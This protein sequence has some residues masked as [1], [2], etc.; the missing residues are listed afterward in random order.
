MIKVEPANEPAQFDA[1]VRTPGRKYLGS[2]SLSDKPDFRRRNYWKA[3]LRE[4]HS[5]YRGVCAYT[6]HWMTPDVGS[7]TVEHFLPKSAYPGLAYE[8]T[9][10]RLVCSRLNSR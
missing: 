7:D 1:S 9:N 10:Y 2:L 5:S 6:C 4:L 8:W 3:I